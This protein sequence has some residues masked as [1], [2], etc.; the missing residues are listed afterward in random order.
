M[1]TPKLLTHTK[2]LTLEGEQLATWMLADGLTDSTRAAAQ[3]F[4]ARPDAAVALWQTYEAQGNMP[5]CITSDEPR[6]EPTAAHD[7]AEKGYGY[8]DCQ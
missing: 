4:A 5:T 2:Q 8:D 7:C 6:T 3:L 1:T